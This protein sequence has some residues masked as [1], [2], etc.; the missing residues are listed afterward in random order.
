MKTKR[1]FNFNFNKMLLMFALIPMITA[2]IV[3]VTYSVNKLNSEL[4][5]STY[6]RLKACAIQ[7]EQY[8]EWD[9]RE[10]ILEADEVTENYIDSLKNE[11][12]EL[13]LFEGDTRWI[14]SVRNDKGE[15]NNGTT[16]DSAIWAAVSKGENYKSDGV[17]IAGKDYYVYYVPVYNDDGSVWGMAFAGEEEAIVAKAEKDVLIT[18]LIVSVIL[19]VVFIVIA[20][21]FTLKVVTPLKKVVAAMTDT[22]KGDLHADTDI[23]STVTETQQLI[24][25]AKTLQNVLQKTIGDTQS[26]SRQLK[27]GATTVSELSTQSHE[28]AN[29]ITSAMEDLANGATSMAQNVQ[30]IN[31]QVISIGAS[32]DVISDKVKEMNEASEKS[33]IANKV[34][35]EYM[36]KLNDASNRSAD[37]VSEISGLIHDCEESAIKIKD[38]VE[39]I[40]SIA[41]QTNLLA[42]NASIEAARAGE[43]GKGFA[44]VATEIK[45]LSEQS[46]NSAEEI[47]IIVEEIFNKVNACVDGSKRLIT[48]INSQ[49]DYLKET[50]EKITDM[51][52]TGIAMSNSAKD[53][54]KETTVL[55]TAKNEV[56]SSVSELSAISEEN[57]ASNEEVSASIT[58]ITSAIQNI[59][60]NSS[61]TTTTADILNDTVN[62]FN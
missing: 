12:I 45:S 38:A 47:K 44:V 36:D 13:T 4:E 41:S 37:G 60:S 59:A 22:S 7:V 43:A 25:A 32:I 56:T 17:V 52:T 10:N 2:I 28:G 35:T 16:C 15:R 9:I 49:M 24:E 46:N 1:K 23:H 6:S 50:A 27:E 8:F 48:I 14:T 61:D 21:L 34:A 20:S 29:Q 5:E 26:I 55:V 39:M 19:L 40:S 51:S 3:T 33:A 57:A 58:Q 54:D 31:E 62:Y 53:I 11:G 18:S 30:M 42:L